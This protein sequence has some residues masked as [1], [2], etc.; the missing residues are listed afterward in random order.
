MYIYTLSQFR[1]LVKEIYIFLALSCAI[2]FTLE[3]LPN[4]LI[5]IHL[6]TNDSH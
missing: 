2:D 3:T 6:S 4:E 5:K 1:I